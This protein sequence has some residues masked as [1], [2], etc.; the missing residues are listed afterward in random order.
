MNPFKCWLALA[1]L[2]LVHGACA[3]ATEEIAVVEEAVDISD[4]PLIPRDALL[5]KN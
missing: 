5:G 1:G 2:V 3:P 4:I